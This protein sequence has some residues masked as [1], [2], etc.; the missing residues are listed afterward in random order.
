MTPDLDLQLKV[1]IKALRDVVTPAI[2][3][4][5]T[6]AAEQLGLSIATLMMVR[7]CLPYLA[8][9]EWV[10]LASAITL[11]RRVTEAVASP[12]L[13]DEIVEGQRLL[14]TPCPMA[15]ALTRARQRI[16][17]TVSEVIGQ[18]D[19]DT[20]ITLM[21][22]VV[23]ESKRSTDVSRAWSKAAG[24]EPEPDQV[25]EFKEILADRVRDEHRTDDQ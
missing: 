23:I 5:Q 3:P 9:R 1:V 22:M 20:S 2:D 15:F 13:A 8:T 14:G 19:E 4:A 7:E 11:G 21:R 17:S 18:A 25:H 24:F 16:L 10:D 6:G 12:T